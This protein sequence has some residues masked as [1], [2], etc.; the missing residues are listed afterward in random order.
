MKLVFSVFMMILVSVTGLFSDTYG[1]TDDGRR[2]VLKEDGTWEYVEVDDQGEYDFRRTNWGMSIEDVKQAED[3]DIVNE[4]NNSL[5]YQSSIAGMDAFLCYVFVGRQLVRTSY[6][7]IMRHVNDN[8]YI[9]DYYT[10]LS[11]LKKKYGEPDDEQI[12][13]KN[14]NWRNDSDMWGHAIKQGHLLYQ[15]IWKTE[16]TEILLTL[17][18]EDY[19]IGLVLQ[20]KSRELG[21][22][23]QTEALEDL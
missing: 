16:R 10:L 4:E 12:V 18:S 9:D 8:A 14:N 20:Y 21:D 17:S 13:W 11:L 15:S 7:I 6:I 1:T 23:E 2:V 22:I 3:E 5:L 19:E